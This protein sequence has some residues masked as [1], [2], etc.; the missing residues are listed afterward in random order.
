[1]TVERLNPEGLEAV[2]GISH[3][4]IA[5]GTRIVHVSGQTGVTAD[6]AVVGTT[7]RE[8]TKQALLNL[9]LAAAAAGATGDD[10]VKV[11]LYVVG[12]DEEA[13]GG[14]FAGL[15]DYEAEVGEAFP[16][17]ASTLVGVTALWRP[18]L[19]IEIDGVFVTG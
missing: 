2:P 13:L 5:T 19:L 18:E 9:R 17:A 16:P 14:I 3:V 8:Q 15:A 4:T 6:G 7:H 1:M 10:A 11:M 12:Y